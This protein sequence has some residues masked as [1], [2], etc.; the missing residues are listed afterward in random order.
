MGFKNGTDGSVDIAVDAIRAAAVPHRF[1]G[2]T[3]QGLAA[4]TITKGNEFGFLILRGG[5][6][7]PNFYEQN[8]AEAKSKM[9]RAKIRA[10]I[11][12]DCSHG[13]SQKNHR[14]QP[15]VAMV[16]AEQVMKGEK[17]IIGV[18]IESH[19]NEGRQD[20]P[21]G[22][23]SDLKKGVSITD[24]CVSFVQTVPMLER[25]AEAVRARRNL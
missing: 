15:G 16:V 6:T 20:I 2:V 11:M 14:N 25:L 5:R 4:I 13:N 9:E 12:V 24:A 21:T 8:I 10:N 7:G 1:M 19:L 17:A 18:M 3:K 23:P 22:G